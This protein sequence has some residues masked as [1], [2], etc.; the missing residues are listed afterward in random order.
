MVYHCK[1]HKAGITLRE[2]VPLVAIT[3][4]LI[5]AQFG[6]TSRNAA[7]QFPQRTLH[8]L[9]ERLGF[10]NGKASA[11]GFGQYA[12]APLKHTYDFQR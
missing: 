12:N 5:P 6:F 2:S 3:L 8:P 9:K 7:N 11:C 4:L 10:C 1:G